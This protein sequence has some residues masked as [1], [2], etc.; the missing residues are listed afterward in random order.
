MSSQFRPLEIPPGVVAT[1]TKKMRSTAWSEVNLVRWSEGQLSPVGGQAQYAYSFA[2]RCRAIHGWYGLDGIHYIAY[3]CETNIYVDTG[4]VLTDITPVDGMEAPVPAGI[5]G[6][7]DG[8]YGDGVRLHATAAFGTTSPN[9]PM[10]TNPGSIVPG[11][12]FST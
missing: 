11:C 12:M 2:S 1:A 10:T 8:L 5:G 7:S 9:I 3:L 4:G 6:Y